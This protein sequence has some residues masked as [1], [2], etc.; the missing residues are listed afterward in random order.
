MPT[1]NDTRVRVDGFWKI[2]PSVRPGRRWTLSPAAL[3]PLQLVG[4]VEHLEP[5]LARQV[6]DAG[7]VT[8]LEGV[9]DGGQASILSPADCGIV[10]RVT[11]SRPQWASVSG[12]SGFSRQ[13]CSCRLPRRAPGER[14]R[15]GRADRGRHELR[16]GGDEPRQRHAPVHALHRAAGDADRVRE[17]PRLNRLERSGVRLAGHQYRHGRHEDV[18]VHDRQ[19]D[20]HR[21]LTVRSRSRRRA[22]SAR[23]SRRR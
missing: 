22:R 2:I 19:G 9:A 8:S 6:V 5:L 16:P 17:R 4:E 18:V 21:Q 23:T 3:R 14:R 13:Y 15:R 12:S 1:S 10:L 7:E 20:H 11:E